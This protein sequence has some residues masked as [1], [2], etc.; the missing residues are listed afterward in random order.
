MINENYLAND[1]EGNKIHSR[2]IKKVGY[3][4]NSK[5]ILHDTL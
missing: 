2:I 1:L 3:K 4:G 5:E